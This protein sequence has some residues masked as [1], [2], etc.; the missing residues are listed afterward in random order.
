[1]AA[2]AVDHRMAE[3]VGRTAV[4]D[5]DMDLRPALAVEEVVAHIPPAAVRMPAHRIRQE[6]AV[7]TGM[8]VAVRGSQA[9]VLMDTVR[10][11]HWRPSSRLAA[12]YRGAPEGIDACRRMEVVCG[13]SVGEV[14]IMSEGKETHLRRLLLATGVGLVCLL[15]S[16]CAATSDEPSLCVRRKAQRVNPTSGSR[17]LTV[18]TC[19]GLLASQ[20]RWC[21]SS[22]ALLLTWWRVLLLLLLLLLRSGAVVGDGALASLRRR[23][24]A[25]QL[26]LRQSFGWWLFRDVTRKAWWG[27]MAG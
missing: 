23:E 4:V 27:W 25:G 24:F 21:S 15:L 3:A 17:A 7:V 6:Q 2:A 5:S 13:R 8:M 1:M 16:S 26:C 22:S 11:H 20:W 19:T 14:A 10:P 9:A 12:W 18:G